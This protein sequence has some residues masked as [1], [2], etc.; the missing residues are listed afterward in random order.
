[1]YNIYI[2]IYI[3]IYTHTHIYIL[4]IYIYMYRERERSY[5]ILLR[6]DAAGRIIVTNRQ[7]CNNDAIINNTSNSITLL[8]HSLVLLC[9][10]FFP[11]R[12]GAEAVCARRPGPVAGGP[13]PHFLP[14][15]FFSA[16]ASL[17]SA[18][19]FRRS[20]RSLDFFSSIF[21]CA[22]FCAARR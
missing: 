3:Y 13:S 10:L 17:A 8:C 7:S 6:R 4:H 22:S 14:L 5:S 20:A 1:M 11:R 21:F 16:S 15:A 2:Y 12:A 18:S 19:S 9:L